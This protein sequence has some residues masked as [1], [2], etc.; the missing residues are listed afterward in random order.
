MAGWLRTL[1]RKRLLK[2]DF[3]TSWL[4]ILKRLPFYR[5]L[6]SELQKRFRDYLKIFVWEKY[7]FGAGGLTITDEHRVVISASAIRLILF[8]DLTYYDELAEIVVY[9]YTFKNPKEEDPRDGEAHRFGTV[10]LSWPA[11]VT[12]LRYECDGHDTAL[13]EFA[14]VL[15]K[16]G[17]SFDGTPRLRSNDHYRPWAE[18]MSRNFVALQAGR[19]P[20]RLVLREYGATTEAEFFAVATESF[21]E[22]PRNMKTLTP[23]L[24]EELQR[25]YGFD[26]AVDSEC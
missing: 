25:F 7:F 11:V 15:D 3:P 18:V 22:R 13:H 16:Q 26:P 1:K 8:L 17:G 2:R 14:H 23:D 4:L 9:P 19:S 24:Y 10:V 12:G 21:F 20:Q 5:R 6:T